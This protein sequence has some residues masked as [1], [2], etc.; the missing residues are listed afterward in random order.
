MIRAAKQFS[1]V[2][3][4]VTAWMEKQLDE[5]KNFLLENFRNVSLVT[6]QCIEAYDKFTAVTEK[7]CNGS[8][9]SHEDLP[10]P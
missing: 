7:D 6:V 5:R 4:E 2:Q 9:S 3:D 10:K 1:E 8:I